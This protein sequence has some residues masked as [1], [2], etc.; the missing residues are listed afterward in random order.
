MDVFPSEEE[1]RAPLLDFLSDTL[2]PCTYAEP[3]APL[4]PGNDTQVHAFRLAGREG[5][6]VLRVFRKGTDARRPVFEATL[7]N[8]LADQGLPVPRARATC[9][10][11]TVI[12]APFFVMDLSAGVPLYGDAIHTD[13]AGIPQ[14]NWWRLLRH[15]GEMLFDMPRLMAEVCLRIHAVDATAVAGA[16][17]KVGL[18]WREITAEGRTQ[19]LAD[20]IE[21][22][23]LE[24][25]RPAMSWLRQNRPPPTDRDVLS[26]CDVQ[27]LNLMM[28]GGVLCNILDW[29]NATIGPPEVEVG[30]TRA[31]YKTIELPLPG[32][33]RLLEGAVGELICRRYTQ[34]YA[35]SRALDAGA[36]A[37]FETLRSCIGLSF[38]GEQV[39]RGEPIRDAWNSDIGVAR[40]I[41]HVRAHTGLDVSIPWRSA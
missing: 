18:P 20:R 39:V 32:P 17:E 31:M 40:I 37:Y 19:Q 11:A 13:E 36:I 26:H 15:G 7:Q 6:L 1:L 12:G 8:A 5:R 23:G 28:D 35:R 21:A 3:P 33:L 9:S 14:A 38:L 4:T 24:G 34:V 41:A 29:A 22:C 25:L 2:G 16:L 10:D 30:W 27:P